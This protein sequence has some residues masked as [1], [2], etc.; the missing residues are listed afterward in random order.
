MA[1]DTV[2]TGDEKVKCAPDDRRRFG[3]ARGTPWWARAWALAAVPVAL[4]AIR[5]RG[6]GRAAGV[7]A[8]ATG[9]AICSFFRDPYRDPGDGVVLAAADG[10]ISAVEREPDGRVRI[11]TFM[12][13]QD[14]HVNRAPTD[15]IVRE[16]RHRAGGYR[17]AFRKDSASNER[18][19]WTIDSPLGELGLV[20]IAGI[21]AR[22]IVPYHAPGQRIERGQRIGM[23]RFGSRVD[24][25]LPAGM[26]AGVRVGQRVRAGLSRLDR[27][28]SPPQNS[29]SIRS[30]RVSSGGQE[31]R[32]ASPG[33]PRQSARWGE[34]LTVKRR[35]STPAARCVS[36][37][38]RASASARP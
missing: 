37:R 12:R 28:S 26:A 24:V 2:A 36:D 15:G 21:A 17:P 16:L 4:Q 14:V 32:L 5:G 8:A 6:R 29:V 23:I 30:L 25:T 31:H 38:S 27:A 35:S 3:L 19:E 20:Q 1:D 11:A 7:A 22:R 9:A 34:S 33:Q 10:V 13:L 18:L